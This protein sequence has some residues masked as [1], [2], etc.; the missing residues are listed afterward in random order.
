MLRDMSLLLR[1]FPP[2]CVHW[3]RCFSRGL[4]RFNTQ[5]V[6]TQKYR[7]L[8]LSSPPSGCSPDSDSSPLSLS[9]LRPVLARSESTWLGIQGTYL[10]VCLFSCQ[11]PR[12]VLFVPSLR[13]TGRGQNYGGNLNKKTFIVLFKLSSRL[14]IP[15]LL[16][17]I[18]LSFARCL[19]KKEKL[20]LNQYGYN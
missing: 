15:S 2:R 1:G 12:R 9:V 16:L 3:V 14:N 20:Q 4:I 7:P 5:P 6:T 11:S 18:D 10:I 8:Y 19:R 13:G 17:D